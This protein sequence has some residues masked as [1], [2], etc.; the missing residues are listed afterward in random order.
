MGKHQKIGLDQAWAI[1]RDWLSAEQKAAVFHLLNSA[2]FV[3]GIRGAAVA[4]PGALLGGPR[5]PRPFRLDGSSGY[6]RG[7][8]RGDL[9]RL[10]PDM[11]VLNAQRTR[12]H[13]VPQKRPA[14]LSL[15][16]VGMG[17]LELRVLIF[18]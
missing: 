2:D 6:R 12:P 15:Q 11:N 8:V 18:F 5:A 16:R 7:G 13:F 14:L 3:T 4:C 9:V 1:R 10:V 17:Q